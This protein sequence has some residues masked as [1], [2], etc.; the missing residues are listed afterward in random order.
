[1]MWPYILLDAALGMRGIKRS[2]LLN[3]QSFRGNS[4]AE[5]EEFKW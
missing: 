4:V 5:E 2:D 3:D 1:M